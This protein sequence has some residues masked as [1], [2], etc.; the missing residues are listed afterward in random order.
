MNNGNASFKMIQQSPGCYAFHGIIDKTSVAT[1]WEQRKSLQPENN[2]LLI[3][4]ENITHSDSAG[5]ALLTCLQGESN[6]SKQNISFLNIP[7]QINQL[8]K[9]CHLQD[10]LNGS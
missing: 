6:K 10:I 3:D 9:L 8:I 1:I 5:L 2:T 7:K 4:L